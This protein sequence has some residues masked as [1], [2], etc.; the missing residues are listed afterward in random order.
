MEMGDYAAAL[1]LYRQA[2]AIRRSAALGENHPD[3]GQSLNDLAWLYKEM[4]DYAAALPLFHQAMA[5]VRTCQ[6]ED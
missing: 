4:G 6:G 2:M 1:P 5:I 3:F